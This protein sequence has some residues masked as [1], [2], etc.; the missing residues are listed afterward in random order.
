[1]NEEFIPKPWK[2]QI[3]GLPAS[4]SRYGTAG[5]CGVFRYAY[6]HWSAAV[7]SP[8]GDSDVLPVRE[9]TQFPANPTVA[10]QC[11]PSPTG[12]WWR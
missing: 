1:M 8:S 2:S 9:I 10:S 6:N 5:Q 4:G 11:A 3:W 7:A 12:D